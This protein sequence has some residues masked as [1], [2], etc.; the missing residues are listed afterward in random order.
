MDK[1]NATR[2][3]SALAVQQDLKKIG[4]DVTLQTL[5]FGTLVRDYLI[6]G[7]YDANL[8]WWTTPPDPDQYSFYA[9][10]Q[11]NNEAA[12]SNARADSLLKR[13]RETVDPVAR[14]NIYNAYQRL[15]MQDPPVLVLYYPK[16]LQAISKDLTGVPDLG[17]RDALRYT[18]RFQLR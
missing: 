6:P 4:M 14:K 11:D 10:G 13:G 12:W 7:K 8:I 15:T 9:T 17:I 1:G 2:E 5:E 16:E 3:Q 18:E